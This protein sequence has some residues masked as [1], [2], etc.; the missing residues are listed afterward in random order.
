MQRNTRPDMP[1]R[2]VGKHLA[3]QG[4]I[5]LDAELCVFRYN[6]RNS[7]QTS[8]DGTQLGTSPFAGS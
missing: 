6:I 3:V 8:F 7:F 5:Q 1:E 2:L 4:D